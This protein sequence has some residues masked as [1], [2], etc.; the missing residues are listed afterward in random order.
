MPTL[1]P[2]MQIS[3]TTATSPTEPSSGG[4][5]W[6]AEPGVVRPVEPGVAVAVLV[7]PVG[8]ELGDRVAAGGAGNELGFDRPTSSVPMA[9]TPPTWI[10]VQ[11]AAASVEGNTAAQSGNATRAPTWNHP[12]RGARD[13]HRCTASSPKA[14]ATVYARQ[15]YVAPG[16]RWY[17]DRG[18]SETRRMPSHAIRRA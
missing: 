18:A 17:N 15:V 11:C 9:A 8:F 10:M 12:R 13:G 4:P 5:C 7:A 3:A 16:T 14:P 1:T 6:L 2:K